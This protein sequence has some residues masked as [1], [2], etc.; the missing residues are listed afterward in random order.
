MKIP[1]LPD[2]AKPFERGILFVYSTGVYEPM[3]IVKVLR[4]KSKRQVYETLKKYKELLPKLRVV[5]YETQ[6]D[7]VID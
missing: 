7:I 1:R 3:M 2:N 4:P 5:S 6:N